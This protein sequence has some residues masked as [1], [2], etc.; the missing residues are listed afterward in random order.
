MRGL[1]APFV[2]G[3]GQC[4]LAVI[5]ILFAAYALVS[6]EPAGGF[7]LTAVVSGALGVPLVRF[8]SARGEP[9]RREALLAVLLLWLLVPLAGALPFWWSGSYTLLDA[10]FESM[11]GFTTTGATVLR[12]FAD[13]PATL[14]MW[15]ALT[16]WI[17][18]V[19][20]I[21]LFIAVFPQ[22]AIAGRQM[23]HAEAPGPTDE[24]LTPRLRH[25]A[26]AVLVV[27]AGLTV[28]CAVAYALAGMTAYDAVAHSFTTLS[29][30]GFSP[31]P[32]S[33]QAFDSAAI[34][35]LG[36]LFMLLAGVNFALQYRALTGRPRDLVRDAEFRA[37][38]FIALGAGL[39]LTAFLLALYPA[40]DAARHGF[41]QV[42]SI[43]TSTGT[44]SA[45]FALWPERAQ[46]VLVLLM[47][48]GGSAG[49]AAGG[50]KIVRWLIVAKLAMREV[51]QLLH[52]RAV[53]PL[54][55]G[56]RAVTDEVVR[57]VSA[58]VTL[59]AALFVG[60]AAVLVVFGADFVTAL[61]AAISC[62]GN[63]GPG[64]G[65]VGPM[66]NFADLHPVSKGL[67]V[68]TMYA[69]RLEVVP[70]FVLF[71]SEWWRLPRRHLFARQRR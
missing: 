12:E 11:S 25:T 8:G 10:V 50:V 18:G 44:A 24:L 46:L 1:F 43:F 60:S 64:L 3:A 68:F 23:F 14:F 65:A 45:D 2:V 58:F 28:A 63:V 51:R 9:T 6:G 36:T 19:G 71:T 61:T 42:V 7:V 5:M 26:S 59:Y 67:L 32:R 33:F 53:M 39:I 35:W 48:A 16:Q 62:L 55:L 17:G 66:Q 27:Y 15:R 40:A 34:E 52:P 37:Y 21:V 57:S 38:L 54:R 13:V 49:S 20:I 69:G 31:H 41:Y 56:G 30:G 4:S 47:F 70:L 29:A 22:L